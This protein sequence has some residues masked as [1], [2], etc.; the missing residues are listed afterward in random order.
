MIGEMRLGIAD[1]L[2]WAVAVTATADHEVVDRRRIALIEPGMPAAPI[3]HEGRDLDDAAT[4]ALIAQAQ[5]SIV[6]ATSAAFDEIAA[7]LPAPVESISLRSWP[8][9]FPQDIAVQRRSPWEAHADPIMYR[10][11][12]SELADARGWEVPPLRGEGCRRSGG[13]D[14]GRASR[15][16]PAG[17]TG[18]AGAALGEG[19]QGRT[20][21][22]DRGRL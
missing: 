19:P 15:R 1:H 12:L 6:R 7:A 21:R 11:L 22:D 3:H 20:R 14:A 5:A 17:S 13:A 18:D 10:K 16:G 2:G 8:L 9:D 4:V